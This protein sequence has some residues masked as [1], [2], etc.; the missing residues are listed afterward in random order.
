MFSAISLIIVLFATASGDFERLEGAALKAC[1]EPDAA[2]SRESL[3]ISDLAGL[4]NVLAG[5]RSAL[6]LV[7]TDE[8]NFARMLVSA[9]LR[10]SAGG[11]ADPTPIVVIERFDT[12]ESGAATTRLARGR[13]TVLFEGFRFDLDS[14]QVVPAGQ[15]DD[16]QFMTEGPA[17]PRL[18]VNAPA[19][20]FTLTKAPK[21]APLA[22]NEPSTGRT[23]IAGDFA[24]RFRLYANGQTSGDLEL[25]SKD[26]GMIQGT[27]RSD[28]TGASYAVRG[29]VDSASP[30]RIRFTIMF[31]RSKQEFDGRLFSDGKGAIA[32]TTTLL[33]K[34]HGFFAIREGG[35][36]APDSVDEPAPSSKK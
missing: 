13:E 10:K 17:G 6:V 2:R 23:I 21:L 15:G 32:G 24:G 25:Q 19:K 36:I 29:D 1:Y 11:K 5:T 28:Q 8:G 26:A 14:G 22:P 27:F 33:D 30:G 20:M 4:P 12:F 3:T 31:P 18:S 16:V 9:A 35:R 34:D 7:K